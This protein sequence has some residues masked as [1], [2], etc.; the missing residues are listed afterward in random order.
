MPPPMD[1]NEQQNKASFDEAFDTAQDIFIKHGIALLDPHGDLA[2]DILDAIPRSRT[3][4]VIYFNPSD[5]SRPIGF[6]PLS[7][8]PTAR[9]AVA[10]DGTLAAFS[11]N[12]LTAGDH[13][14]NIPCLMR[15]ACC[16][17][18]PVVPYWRSR[19]Y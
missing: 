14:L 7:N 8:V 4:N 17:I 19:A 12:G 1:M 18:C 9:R 16:L 6:N 3:R 11:I 10:A 15:C 2:F 5:L 13:G